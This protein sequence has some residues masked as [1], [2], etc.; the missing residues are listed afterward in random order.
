MKVNQIAIG[1]FHHFHLARQLHK[2]DILENIYT[3]YPKF[4]LRDEVGIPNSKIRTFPWIQTPYMARTKFGLTRFKNFED[5]WRLAAYKSLDIFAA[6]K[7]KEKSI[8]IALSSTGL[9]SGIRTKELGG[10]YIC[11]RGSSHIRYQDNLLSE[12]YGLWKIAFH[13]NSA[14]IIEREENEYEVSDYITVP[15]NFVLKSFLK[16]GIKE[17][18][19]VKIPYGANLERFKKI[20]EPENDGFGVLWVGQVSLRKGFLYAL[21]AFQNLKIKNKKFTVI[22]NIEANIK[23]LILKIG[24]ENVNFLGQVQNSEL[25]KFYNSNHVFVLPSI[26]E[27]LAM[28][29]GEALACGCPIIVTSNTGSE[30]LITNGREGIIVPIRDVQAITDAFYSVFENPEF[31]M[32]L[33]NNAI[34]R[35][36][37]LNGWDEYGAS[38]FSFLSKLR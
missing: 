5:N 17:E 21:Q 28:V 16:Q 30:D 23:D 26:E 12:E 1:R 6:S 37:K 3:G 18:K 38:F 19:L 11:D 29:Q 22:G 32:Y 36:R 4:K 7:I 35:V 8:L 31:R 14:K 2:Y 24:V 20:S 10:K 9:K 25:I 34:Q 27:G 15:S 33:S 13:N